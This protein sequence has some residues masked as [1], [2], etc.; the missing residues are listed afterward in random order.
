MTIAKIPFRS[1]RSTW[2]DCVV[3]TAATACIALLIVYFVGANYAVRGDFANFWTVSHLLW[4]GELGEIYDPPRFAAHRHALFGGS[5]GELASYWPYPPNALFLVAPLALL[6]SFL[7]YVFWCIVTLAL[8]AASI[9]SFFGDNR[10]V[11][12]LVLAPSSCANIIFGQTGF[13]TSALLVGGLAIFDRCPLAAGLLFGLLSFKPQLGIMLPLA[14]A[15]ARLWKPFVAAALAALATTIASVAVF[16]LEAWRS[17]LEL[18]L[19]YELDYAA[20]GQGPFIQK[21]PTVFVAA[22]LIGAPANSAYLLQ[23]VAMVAVAGI[24]IWTFR[25]MRDRRA[26]AAVLLVGT[27]LASPHLHV[28]DMSIVSVAAVVLAENARAR[29]PDFWERSAITLAWVVP[30]AVIALS[31]MLNMGVPHDPYLLAALAP[32]ITA[33]LMCY[34]V[35]RLR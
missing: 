24:V 5:A 28:Y 21:A 10:R 35:A 20:H 15:A 19:P 6:P 3:L 1:H 27:A 23:A 25:H 8:F 30:I 2:F 29:A 18:T 14:L 31:A 34:I 26:Q 11:L 7:S 32:L 17:Y 33:A 13:V 9:R 12:M 16:G 4:Q 22:R